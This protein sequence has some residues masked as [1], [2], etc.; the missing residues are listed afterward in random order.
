MSFSKKIPS[1]S[2][3]TKNEIVTILLKTRRHIIGNLSFQFQQYFWKRNLFGENIQ[4]NFLRKCR[5][6]WVNIQKCYWPISRKVSLGVRKFF[7]NSKLLQNLFKM[8][9]W[10]LEEQLSQHTELFPAKVEKYLQKCKQL[11]M[12]PEKNSSGLVEWFFTKLLKKIKPSSHKSVP[13][14]S[15]KSSML[16]FKKVSF[17]LKL[18]LWTH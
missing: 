8:F 1:V 7:W 5:S 11:I 3:Y 16:N 10:P 13:D 14:N 18:L 17:F 2:R 12:I 6:V 9:L 4:M 15:K